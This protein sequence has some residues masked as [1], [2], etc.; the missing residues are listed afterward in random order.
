MAL[1]ER[2]VEY[3]EGLRLL[4]RVAP[5]RVLDVGSGKS[6]WP[7]LVRSLGYSKHRVKIVAMDNVTDYWRGGALLPP[8]AVPLVDDN[9]LEPRHVR[10]PFDVVTCIST[11]EHI[12][13]PEAAVQNMLHLLRPGGAL[14]MTF[15]FHPRQGHPNIYRHPACNIGRGWKFPCRVFCDGDLVEWSDLDGFAHHDLQSY[16]VF[17]G[18]Y[19]GC[20]PRLDTVQAVD[21]PSAGQMAIVTIWKTD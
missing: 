16:R 14:Y 12:D 10:G 21:D 4:N 7:A 17:T 15:P 1:T 9:I 3:A 11:L 6:L 18:P 2:T 8:Q 5:H 20:G 13:K 19:W